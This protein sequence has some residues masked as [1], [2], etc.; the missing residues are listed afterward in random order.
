MALPDH[1][2]TSAYRYEEEQQWEAQQQAQ[3]SFTQPQTQSRFAQEQTRGVRPQQLLEIPQSNAVASSA[4]QG[5]NQQSSVPDV[6]AQ[7][8][9]SMTLEEAGLSPSLREGYKM[10]QG[11]AW[12]QGRTAPIV[13]LQKHAEEEGWSAQHQAQPRGASQHTLSESEQQ[14]GAVR[15]SPAKQNPTAYSA[16]N[17]NQFDVMAGAPGRGNHRSQPPLTELEHQGSWVE[18]SSP[19][20]DTPLQP[21]VR[22]PT[23][24]ELEQIAAWQPHGRD[25]PTRDLTELEQQGSFTLTPDQ[26]QTQLGILLPP[27]ATQA[28]AVQGAELAHE[29]ARRKGAQ[30]ELERQYSQLQLQH[31]QVCHHH[32]TVPFFHPH[33]HTHVVFTRHHAL[34]MLFLMTR[35]SFHAACASALRQL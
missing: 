8:A 23:P 2:S 31:Q 22:G 35:H 3:S 16:A 13:Q 21:P 29:L 32:P 20:Q 11:G 17:S 34:S 33:C 6:Q 10:Q 5:Y 15:V 4:G 1:V 28:E 9:M 14:G 26:S 24:Q 25:S 18:S 12:T 27:Q 19:Q 7:N 30:A